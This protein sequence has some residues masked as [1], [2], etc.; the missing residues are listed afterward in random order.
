MVQRLS[1][2]DANEM[3]PDARRL[4]LAASAMLLSTSSQDEVLSG[5]LDIASEVLAA[6]AYAVW[7]EIDSHR[8]WRAIAT[9]GL[10][11]SYRT[12]LEVHGDVVPTSIMAVEQITAEPSLLKHQQAYAEEGICSMLVVPLASELHRPGTI[13]FYWRSEHHFTLRDLDYAAALANLA[14]AAI[15]QRELR[16]QARR[17]RQRLSFL[18]DASAAL[19]SSLDY[20]ATLNQVARLAVP[21]IADWCVVHV[22][23]NG[24]PNRIVVAHGDP[25]M[26]S[27]AQEYERLYPEQIRDDRGLG[28]VLRTGRPEVFLE[29]TDDMLTAAA[30]SPEHLKALRSLQLS[31]SILVPLTSR[32]KVVGAV[33]LLRV[34]SH[35]HLDADD[36]QLAEDLAR[37]AGTAIENA[38]L[39]RAV[40]KQQSELRLSQAAA[41]MG[42]WSWDL[43]KGQIVW[44]DEFKLLH[45][46]PL[47]SV[48]GFDGG[49][50][51][52]HPDDREKVLRDL[53]EVLASDAEQLQFEHRA[54]TPAGRTIWVHSR[55]SILRDATGKAL[56]IIGISMD[57]TE[58][59]LA[60]DALRRSEKLAAAGRLAATVAHEVNNPLEALTNLIYLVSS[61]EG[62]PAEAKG[63]LS[64]AD[65]ELRRMA[66]V[67]RQTLGFY[68]ESD[69]A[70]PVDV[71][72]AATEIAALYRTRA[73]SRAIRLTCATDPGALVLANAG[74]IKQILANLISNAIDASAE[75][76]VGVIVRRRKT[77]VELVVCDDGTGIP[78]KHRARI[79]E[80]FFTTKSE[81]GTGLGLWV[82][83]GLVE[84]H[85]GSIQILSRT[86]PGDS[87]TNITITFPITSAAS[88]SDITTG[89]AGSAISAD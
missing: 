62:L 53:A 63:H 37:R 45:D 87:G 40:L 28:A 59:R 61:T 76:T 51:L 34:G 60:E 69:V 85:G 17:E 81:V 39:H 58:W 57:V 78:E 32:D 16:V 84:K 7:R 42:S 48:P 3:R 1:S 5:I 11:P 88:P 49:S 71:G 56:A 80:P 20:E 24:T 70:G 52:I 22:I 31:G 27:S 15:N 89:V 44:S 64:I 26:L 29:I 30:V 10:S 18:A 50:N 33:R 21:H 65:G 66:Q 23:E 74:E 79:F 14:A 2:S 43:V 25:E 68:R 8:T 72:V 13:T 36:V 75:G 77:K 86:D 12:E 47:D 73:E 54:V 4:L 41:R 83:K 35:R 46:L 82:S 9:R 38:Q 55:G 67:V 6:D 19:A